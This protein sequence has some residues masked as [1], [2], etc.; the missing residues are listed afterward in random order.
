MKFATDILSWFGLINKVSNYAKLCK[1][2]SLIRNFV[3]SK[4]KF[5]WTENLNQAFSKSKKKIINAI[6]SGVQIFNLENT[7][8]LRPDMSKQ[9]LG[10]MLTQKYCNSICRLLNYYTT[11]WK[12]T[13]ECSRFLNGKE[14]N[15]ASIAWS[16][17]SK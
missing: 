1:V 13:L 12:V 8:C 10:N 6:R 4:H 2:M 7:I 17:E 11:V 15:Y 14:N 5:I 3:S 16:L 9:G